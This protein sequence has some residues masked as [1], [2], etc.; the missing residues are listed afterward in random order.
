MPPMRS[1]YGPRTASQRRRDDGEFM[2]ERV[3]VTRRTEHSN[4]YRRR[5][6]AGEQE[7]GNT[8]GRLKSERDE[9]IAQAQ[10][11]QS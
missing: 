4:Q 7:A 11:N 1:E 9:Q 6:S 10:T 3:T 5:T 8:S 2:R